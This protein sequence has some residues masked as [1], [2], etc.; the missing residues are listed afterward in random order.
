LKVFLEM[1]RTI[2]ATALVLI[3]SGCSTI[4]PLEVFSKPI[5]K[6]PLNLN[7]PEK[8][9]LDDV[10][11][12]VVTEQNAKEIFEQLK[13]KNIDPVLIGLTDNDYE[14]LS[15]NM[16]K[17]RNYI[18]QYQYILNEYRKYYEDN[19]DGTEKKSGP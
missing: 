11:W 5:E 1:K 6:T 17:I 10:K 12:R 13:E 18:I 19:V 8:I 14:R 16:N 3:L 4:K 7:N 2:I 9:E 15:L